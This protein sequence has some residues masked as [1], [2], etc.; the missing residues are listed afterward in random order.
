VTVSNYGLYFTKLAVLGSGKE[1]AE[2]TFRKGLNII[3]GAS[4]TGKSYVV[5][6]LNYIL[7]GKDPP[8]PIRESIGYQK[9]Q[10]EMR[11][12]DGEVFTLSRQFG[13]NSIYMAECSFDE[14]GKNASTKL[15]AVHSD[16]NDNLSAY[17][18]SL[19]ELGGKKLK[20]NR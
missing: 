18:L 19:L 17:L 12:F 20:K 3:S 7:G 1:T 8:K 10:A 4:E 11:T 13:D 15:S 16:N 6:C 2:V 14:F 5:E 9:V